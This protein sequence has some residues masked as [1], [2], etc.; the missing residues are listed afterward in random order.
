M[1]KFHV[2]Y[3]NPSRSHVHIIYFNDDDGSG[4]RIKTILECQS[5]GWSYNLDGIND[6]DLDTLL[7]SDIDP[8]SKVDIY[9]QH[10][11][12]NIVDGISFF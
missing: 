4:R 2:G 3:D 1:S 11:Q 6:D 12:S 7:D 8:D 10:L 9:Y 5:Q